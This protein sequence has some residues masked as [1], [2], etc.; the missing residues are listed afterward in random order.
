[1]LVGVHL[2]LTPHDWASLFPRDL[3]VYQAAI[4]AFAAGEDPY[5]QARHAHG[6]IFTAPPFVWEL[7]RLAAH[8]G[9]AAD[10]GSVLLAANA[11]SVLALPVILSRLLLGPGLAR[12]ALGAGFFFI[13][14]DGSGFFTALVINNGTPLYALIAA[15]LIPAAARGRWLGFHAAVAL[16]TAFKPFYAAFWIVPLLADGPWGGQ[17]AAS[18]AGLGV[19]AM[20]YL[21]PALLAPK[22]MSAWLHALTRQTLS[23][24]L[25]GDNLLGAVSH[26]PG[27]HQ[28]PGA[29][30][31]AQLAFSAVLLAAAF[32]LGRFDRARR[33]AALVLIA[34]LL[35][36]RAMRYDLSM[37]AIPLL[38]V[39]AGILFS[40]RPGP[41]AQAT[42]A[43]MLAWVM[44]AFS[45][46]TTAD[47]VL[48]AS[49]TVAA[50]LG[51][52]AASYMTSAPPRDFS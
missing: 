11:I 48:Y 29:A 25:L 50:L 43:I 15:G 9:L 4:D 27:A 47:G 38:A 31:E 49:L 22:L 30:Y 42:W 5:Q 39:I 6:L 17:L 7:Y 12:I 1:M 16:A 24:G 34:V 45:Q 20:T 46:N 32:G 3:K 37:A 28:Q 52:I 36:P 40:G 2:F 26:Q 23:E 18:I 41:M 14:F 44:T 33:I 19:A 35:N 8:S 21:A 51:A 13:A 10:L